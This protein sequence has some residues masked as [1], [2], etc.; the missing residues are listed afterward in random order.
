MSK[1]L[2]LEA[3]CNVVA[4]N[5]VDLKEQNT[6]PRKR[7]LDNI[8]KRYMYCCLWNTKIW[9]SSKRKYWANKLEEVGA[10]KIRNDKIGSPICLDISNQDIVMRA[11]NYCDDV[12]NGFDFKVGNGWISYPQ[13]SKTVV[14]LNLIDAVS[15]M[16]YREIVSECGIEYEFYS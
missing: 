14:G 4:R 15:E 11:Y 8:N 12:V 6:H 5:I 2:L 9:T 16:L 3:I 10:I 1:L 13:L 7:E